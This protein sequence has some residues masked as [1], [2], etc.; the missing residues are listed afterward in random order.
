MQ[1]Y[2]C[3]ETG[4]KADYCQAAKKS[5]YGGDRVCY[6]C[7][8]SGH[9]SRDCPEEKKPYSRMDGGSRSNGGY[10]NEGYGNN[11]GRTYGNNGGDRTCYNCQKTGHISRDCPEEKKAYGGR[12]NGGYNNDSNGR[13]GYKTYGQS[14]QDSGSRS[15]YNCQK[16]GHISRDCPEERKPRGGNYSS[17]AGNASRSNDGCYKCGD[18]GHMSKECTKDIQCFKCKQISIYFYNPGFWQ[19]ASVP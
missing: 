8:K 10:N 6:N 1:C 11:G 17:Y 3:G 7:Q 12:S 9:V 16:T 4:H 14:N 18:K 19:S 2:N 15:C 13:D 5:N